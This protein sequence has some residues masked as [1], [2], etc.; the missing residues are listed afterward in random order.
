M[1]LNIWAHRFVEDIT[2][3]GCFDHRWLQ[4]GFY[5]KVIYS[6]L[7]LYVQL[8]LNKSFCYILRFFTFIFCFTFWATV[9]VVSICFIRKILEINCFFLIGC[10]AISLQYDLGVWQFL[11]SGL[12]VFR[13]D[14]GSVHMQMTHSDMRKDSLTE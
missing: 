7:V 9:T 13:S 6:S 1:S 4:S 12:R 10:T 11:K 8:Y 14:S 5:D 3:C 2:V